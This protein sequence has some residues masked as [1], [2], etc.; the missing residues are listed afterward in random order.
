MFQGVFQRA[1]GMIF[2]PMATL[3]EVI[4]DPRPGP[5]LAVVSICVALSSALFLTTGVGRLA[6]LDEAVRQLEAFGQVVSD[7]RYARLERLK[8][9]AAYLA[10]AQ[11]LVGT[12]LIAVA[13]AAALHKASRS[14]WGT[15][16]SFRQVLGVVAASSVIMALRQLF[17]A[18]LDYV[19]ESMTNATNVGM[20]LPSLT[21][22]TF[23]ARLLGAID[24]FVIW[25]L[26]VL[27]AGLAILYRCPMRR[28]AV[29]L[30]SF[31]GAMAFGL[32]LVLA[33]L[34]GT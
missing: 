6:W 12:P 5:M 13:L 32:A 20:L 3:V 29:V 16:A 31:Y 14:L 33:L 19:R 21:E 4:Q 18:P 23:A 34:G 25:C 15:A 10:L 17:V 24:V 28:I 7:T 11:G 27:A 26:A 22:G 30:L 8:D 9:S 2:S 1:R